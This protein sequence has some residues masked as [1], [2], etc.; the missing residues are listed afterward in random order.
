MLYDWRNS[1]FRIFRFRSKNFCEVEFWWHSISFSTDQVK[2]FQKTSKIKQSCPV[3][4]KETSSRKTICFWSHFLKLVSKLPQ[5]PISPWSI[6]VRIMDVMP[7]I[8]EKKTKFELCLVCYFW[9]TSRSLSF[10]SRVRANGGGHW[11]RLPRF[12]K[13]R[14]AHLTA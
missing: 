11:L 10:L 3:I 9:K 6:K 14:I 1:S 8:M 12:F 13:C 7:M 2:S 4:F 5:N